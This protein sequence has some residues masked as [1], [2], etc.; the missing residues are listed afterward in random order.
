MTV[1]ELRDALNKLMKEMP[2]TADDNIYYFDNGTFDYVLESLNEVSV[3]FDL[4]QAE[5]RYIVI[6]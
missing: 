5:A 4:N 2:N 6:K 3:E 1:V